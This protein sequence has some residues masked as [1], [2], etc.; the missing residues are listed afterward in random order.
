M[1]ECEETAFAFFEAH[2]QFA[3]AAE[4]TMRYLDHSAP[5]LV[6]PIAPFGFGCLAPVNNM[7]DVTVVLDGAKVCRAAIARV[8]AQMFASPV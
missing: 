4:P 2:E 3:E 6:F 1:V 8:D 5:G 7:R